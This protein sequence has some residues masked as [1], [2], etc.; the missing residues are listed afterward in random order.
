VLFILF[1]KLG[2]QFT[3]FAQSY[4]CEAG[5]DAECQAQ[6]DIQCAGCGGGTGWC[7]ITN[8]TTGEGSCKVTC[9][10]CPAACTNWGPWG[11]CDACWQTRDCLDDPLKYQIRGCCGGPGGGTPTT[12]VSVTATPS[13]TPPPANC[14]QRYFCNAS[15]RSC[16]TANQSPTN[17]T[18][19]T[20][21]NI[22]C[23]GSTTCS[24]NLATYLPGVAVGNTCYATQAACDAACTPVPTIA[25][26]AKRWYCNGTTD[27]CAQTSST[28]DRDTDM[29]CGG[30]PSC[31]QNLVL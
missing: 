18:Y 31:A 4:A 26:C 24:Q 19:D 29:Q 30:G 14:T 16:L 27:T 15:T 8:P 17:S 23:G 1:F 25:Q 10:N 7:N 2:S 21:T 12:V 6:A 28:Y 3:V 9:E 11:S 20:V 5:N 13:V 22:Q